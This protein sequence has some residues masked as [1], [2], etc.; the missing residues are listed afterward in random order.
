MIPSTQQPSPA[1]GSSPPSLNQ[2]HHHHDH[3]DGTLIEERGK[4]DGG[5]SIA[6]AAQPLW[7]TQLLEFMIKTETCRVPPSPPVSSS[8]KVGEEVAR[9]LMRLRQS[10]I[11][12]Y[13]TCLTW[14]SPNSFLSSLIPFYPPYDTRVEPLSRYTYLYSQNIVAALYGYYH[15]FCLFFSPLSCLCK[16]LF[17]VLFIWLFGLLCNILS[18]T[19]DLPRPYSRPFHPLALVF[20]GVHHYF[21]SWVSCE[22]RVHCVGY[23]VGLV[24]LVL[25][26]LCDIY[27]SYPRVLEQNRLERKRRVTRLNWTTY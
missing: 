26:E 2:H 1:R 18:S 21:Y 10:K 12:K 6:A 25:S 17:H 16:L 13:P 11:N 14:Y 23:M 3:H 22:L 4:S 9:N 8:T 7:G 24:Q 20:I 19:P 5:S 27:S 15:D